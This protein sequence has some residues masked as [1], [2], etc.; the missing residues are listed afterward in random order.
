MVI[1]LIVLVP[2]LLH[3]RGTWEWSFLERV[4]NIAY[5]LRVQLTMPESQGDRIAIVDLDEK[6]L[7][8]R[9]QWPWPRD[10]VAELVSALFER[11]EVDVAGFDIVFAEA[12]RRLGSQVLA[13]LA[14]GELS[15][16]PEYMAA[17][18][19]LKP[20]LET[21]RIF[22]ETLAE[23]RAVLGYVM[24]DSVVEGVPTTSGALPDPIIAADAQ[25]TLI[26][27]YEAEGYTGNLEELQSAATSGGFFDNPAVDRDGVF[28]RVPLVQS[29]EGA[30]YESLALA[31]YR[32][33]AGEPSVG[34]HFFG[35]DDSRRDGLDLE[36][37]TVGE[38]RVPVDERV[39][40]LVPYRGSA[41]SFPYVS[42]TD[43]MSGEAPQHL[44]KDKIVLVGTSAPGL[45]DLRVTPVAENYPGVEVH[46]NIISGIIDDRIKAHPQYVRG[47]EV[48][49][50]VGIAVL[51]T[52]LLPRLS[53]VSGAALALAMLAAVFGG[54]L[55]FWTAGNLVIPIAAPLS[56]TI[57]LYML[58]TIFGY[59][60]E[61]R[62][63]RQLSRR[64]GQYIPP[65]LV[66]EMDENPGLEFSMEGEIRDMSVLFS[67]VR[68]FTSISEQ[69][70]ARDLSKLM[71]EFLTPFTRIIHN[72][73]GTIDKY[74]GDAIMAFWGAPLPDEDH[75]RHALLAG[76]EMV[77]A[78][79]Q[80]N[81][82]FRE[83]GWPEIRIGVGVN[84]GDMRVGNMGSE[85]RVAYTVMGDAVNLGSRLEGLTKEYK[86]S[87]IISES[88][89]MAVPE[90]AC[91]ELDRVRVK[92]K[93][94]PVA[95]Y[96]PI[97]PRDGLDKDTKGML[98]RHKQ[99][100]A[101]Y[102]DQR[103]DEAE[104]EFFMLS[105]QYSDRRI[106][107][108][109]LDRVNHFRNHPPEA[110]WDGTWVFTTK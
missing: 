87:I 6:S 63:K 89:K 71:N 46:A 56:F 54:N 66:E 27:F 42:A 13:D 64:F 23:G 103:W 22:A 96:Q 74:M 104:R 32:L 95:I 98:R 60:I 57:L 2:F 4:E 30:I 53:V 36:W 19:R 25:D 81:S 20:Q 41:Y 35:G 37:V 33:W 73:R 17:Y 82:R 110:S 108:I 88:T 106:F 72:E 21:D 105:Q 92:G 107:A 48:M 85:F 45:L 80:I 55:L 102:R 28:R 39:A 9:G 70:E 90:F 51:L 31:T 100:L 29:Y 97:A 15:E 24:R 18:Q 38:V 77:G 34:F 84:S 10:Q 101:L 83:R 44:L 26:D 58:H 94:E 7:A 67:D 68:D 5:D 79:G 65:E 14:E 86:A 52:L 3:N 69:M 109:Y 62:G 76:M 93:D 16:D 61:S 99:A 12:D 78:L 47:I 49:G 43:V 59:L 1:T 8:E 91:L 75:A 11:Y 40:V 50:L